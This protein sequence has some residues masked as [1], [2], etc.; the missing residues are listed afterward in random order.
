MLEAIGNFFTNLIHSISVLPEM[1]MRELMS[2][3]PGVVFRAVGS[4]GLVIAGVVILVVLLT[5][6]TRDSS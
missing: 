6:R 5:Y 1:I 2:F 4:R 3:D